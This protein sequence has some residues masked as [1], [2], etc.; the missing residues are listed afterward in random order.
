ME[1]S[2]SPPPPRLCRPVKPATEFHRYCHTAATQQRPENEAS[3]RPL[4]AEESRGHWGFPHL[5]SR[6]VMTMMSFYL[7]GQLGM[8]QQSVDAK[9]LEH[10]HVAYMSA[11]PRAADL[12]KAEA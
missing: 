1:T 9:T 5:Y 6:I 12:T 2:R 7:T 4:V 11:P 8:K 10:T 3:V